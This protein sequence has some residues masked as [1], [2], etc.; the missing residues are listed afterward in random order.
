M[1]S[2]KREIFNL[3]DPSI[4]CEDSIEVNTNKGSGFVVSFIA[5]VF[6]IYVVVMSN[7]NHFTIGIVGGSLM[8]VFVVVAMIR[9]AR[10]PNPLLV[11]DKT[12]IQYYGKTYSW[13]NIEN[14]RCEWNE[15]GSRITDVRCYLTNKKSVS[16]MTNYLK[17]PVEVW[18]NYII[19]YFPNK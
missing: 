10:Q 8:T 16:I 6:F 1:S 12:G 7:I 2:D 14:I 15:T 13:E 18:A 19:K 4:V 3:Y 11:I 17:Q 9:Y 5:L